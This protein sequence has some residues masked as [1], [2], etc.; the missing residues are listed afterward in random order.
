[1]GK[2]RHLPLK[3]LQRFPT[4]RN[5]CWSNLSNH[6]FCR[7]VP[8]GAGCTGGFK[9]YLTS[10]KSPVKNGLLSRVDGSSEVVASYC[11]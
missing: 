10:T 1:M 9:G 7:T 2:L 3:L 4:P 6:L 8:A 5:V 11:D